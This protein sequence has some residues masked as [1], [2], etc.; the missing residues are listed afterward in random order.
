MIPRTTTQTLRLRLPLF[1]LQNRSFTIGSGAAQNRIYQP[2]R[3]TPELENL[4]LLSASSRVP[5]ITLWTA[6]WCPSCKVIAPVVRRLIE[7]EHVGR[8]EGGVGFAE[9]QLDSPDI[10]ELGIRYTVGLLE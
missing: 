10:G 2:V 9:V 7:E 1:K 3:N 8:E 5:L 4:L 6:S